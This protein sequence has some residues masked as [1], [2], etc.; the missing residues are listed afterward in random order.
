MLR[1]LTA[2]RTPRKTINEIYVQ[3]QYVIILD[4]ITTG[5]LYDILCG[6]HYCEF[7]LFFLLMFVFVSV[8][9]VIFD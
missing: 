2:K 9:S 3:T 8:N 1:L 6:L 5:L 4:L 7:S